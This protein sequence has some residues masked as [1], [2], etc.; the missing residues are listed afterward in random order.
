[1]INTTKSYSLPSHQTPFEVYFGWKPHWIGTVLQESDQTSVDGDDDDSDYPETDL[2]DLELTEIEA[3][4]VANNLNVQSRMAK[5]ATAS[6]I[7]KAGDLAT[8]K[9]LPK[10]R[11]TGELLRLLVRVIRPVRG[12]VQYKLMSKHGELKGLFPRTELNPTDSSSETTLG[13]G[14]HV[15]NS[16]NG[17]KP[18]LITLSK[19]VQLEN[20][21]GTVAMA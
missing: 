14:I 10:L 15:Q 5:K 6:T 17:P 16:K 11:L 13:S 3:Q 19:A 2:E 20:R 12:G 21:R 18:V 8:L 4:V 7:F 1:V 9:I